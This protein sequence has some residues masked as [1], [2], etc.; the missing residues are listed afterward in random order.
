MPEI[1][2]G[3][4]EI[5]KLLKK[6]WRQVLENKKYKP[7]FKR[8]FYRNPINGKPFLVVREYLDY[9]IGCNKN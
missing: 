7:A 3:R 1:V 9:I 5:E 4:K 6:S 2:E 8:L